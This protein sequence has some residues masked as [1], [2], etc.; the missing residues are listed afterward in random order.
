MQSDDLM[1]ND[2]LERVN[3]IFEG[4]PDVGFVAA[5]CRNID[6][7]GNVIY[8]PDNKPDYYYKAGDEALTAILT[9][10][11]PHVSSIIMRKSALD[12][13]GK[14]NEDIWHGPDVEFDAR[15][16]SKF[17]YYKIGKVST[18]FRRHG[19]NR[20]NLEYFRNDYL[21]NHIL[22]FT[23]AW[24]YLSE[25]GRKKLGIHNL[26]KYVD[27][28]AAQ[29]AIGGAILMVAYGKSDLGRFYLRKA[30]E[31]KPSSIFEVKY[32]KAF[33]INLFPHLGQRVMVQRLN[34]S[35][36]DLKIIKESKL[37]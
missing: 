12:Q 33:A 25:E 16:A 36:R 13:I 17:D 6:I 22:K 2:Y 4:H 11:F 15:L 3:N 5:Y 27:N 18:S 31:L 1:D 14:I 10:G 20:G 24:G 29:M 26:T 32:W 21:S 23:L 28:D 37:Q 8:T 7:T 30:I 34:I 19:T 35:K 9:K